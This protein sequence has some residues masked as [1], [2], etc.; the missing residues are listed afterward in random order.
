MEDGI[1]VRAARNAH[2]ES[3]GKT[4]EILKL[5]GTQTLSDALEAAAQTARRSKSETVRGLLEADLFGHLWVVQSA[6][7]SATRSPLARPD[8]DLDTALSALALM[9]GLPTDDYVAAVLREHVFGLFHAE[10]SARSVGVDKG[11]REGRREG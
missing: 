11:S 2:F 6:S 3:C 7:G 4:S 9:H 10:Q 5:I 1:S 8:V